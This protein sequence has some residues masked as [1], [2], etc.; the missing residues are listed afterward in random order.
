MNGKRLSVDL[1]KTGVIRPQRQDF[2][3]THWTAS[4]DMNV[5]SMRKYER[6]FDA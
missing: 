1:I 5:F 4:I 3:L 2:T 6:V